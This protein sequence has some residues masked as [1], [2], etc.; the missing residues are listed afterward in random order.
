MLR[1]IGSRIVLIHVAYLVL[2]VALI[3]ATALHL[4]RQQ[5]DGL[6]VN[7]AGR[8]RMLTQRM[9]HQ[10]M[11]YAS[12]VDHHQDT[13]AARAR[14]QTSMQVFERTLNAL[15]V[16][17]Q[18]PLDLESVNV[19]SLPPASI[20]VR[21]QLDRVL[22]VYKQYRS[23]SKGILDGDASLRARGVAYITE[24]N[25]ELL[26]EM[27]SA[28]NLMQA[29][30]E[31]R[32]SELYVIQAVA[33]GLG[34]LFSRLLS[35]LTRRSVVHP[36]EQLNAISNAMSRGDVY[37]PI[38]IAGPKEIRE[39]GSSFERLRVSLKSVLGEANSPGSLL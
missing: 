21:H 3:G 27:N 29:E 13:E 15:Q 32:V 7:L 25:T 12:R 10:L 22:G 8:Q 34:L 24:H 11:A 33:L 14:V 17:G 38:E 4:R 37:R 35:A 30:A 6:V 20:H 5:S 39:L 16:G 28:V 2:L 9:T 18:A 23:E 31:G 26:S 1:S 19:R 36:L